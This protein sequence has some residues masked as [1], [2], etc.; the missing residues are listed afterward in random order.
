MK[1]IK[2]FISIVLTIVL[3][4]ALETKFGDIP[5]IGVFLNPST[6]SLA[7]CRKQAYSS[8]RKSKAERLTGCGYY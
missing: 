7:K 2:A 3:I 4:V 1:F 5:P 8:G 6:G